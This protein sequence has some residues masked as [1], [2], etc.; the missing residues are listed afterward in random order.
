[1][2]HSM[3]IMLTLL[4][5]LSLPLAGCLGGEE[6]GGPSDLSGD[7]EVEGSANTTADP[8]GSDDGVVAS[9]SASEEI[10]RAEMEVEFDASSSQIPG[11]GND[12]NETQAEFLWEFGDGSTGE[13]VVVSHA[14]A[15]PGFFTVVLNV[16]APQGSS[17]TTLDVQVLPPPEADL[18][19]TWDGSFPVG[20]PVGGGSWVDEHD[21][22]VDFPQTAVSIDL[23]GS[24]TGASMDLFLLDDEGEEV[25]S[26]TG[27]GTE[28][29]VTAASLEAGSYTVRV[30]MTS[31]ASGSYDLTAVGTAG[32]PAQ[33]TE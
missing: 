3:P 33:G 29:Q 32:I 18:N 19:E 22:S 13:G 6:P 9:F 12:T 2:H 21:F 28:K 20:A 23:A 31:G 14:Y 11:D 1:M 7:P 8:G 25:D 30:H 24:G 10:L 4:L 27:S 17:N 26:A 16:S 15:N 5:A